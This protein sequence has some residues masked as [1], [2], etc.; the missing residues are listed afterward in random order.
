[1]YHLICGEMEAAIDWFEKDVIGRRP[2]AP[3][4]ALAGFLRPLRLTHAGR[5]LRES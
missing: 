5:S 3:S 2:N 4:I 1:M